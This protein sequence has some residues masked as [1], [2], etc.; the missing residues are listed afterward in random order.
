[1]CRWNIYFFVS[2]TL[3][4]KRT[5]ILTCLA[6]K[7]FLGALAGTHNYDCL[8]ASPQLATSGACY[9]ILPLPSRSQH[10]AIALRVSDWWS[11]PL[12]IVARQFWENIYISFK[13]NHCPFTPRQHN[14]FACLTLWL[15]ISRPCRLPDVRPRKIMQAASRD[16]PSYHPLQTP[17][18][19]LKVLHSAHRHSRCCSFY[20]VSPALHK[21]VYEVL[22]EEGY[23]YLWPLPPCYQSSIRR[24]HKHNSGSH[25]HLSSPLW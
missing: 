9:R 16:V 5:S 12:F 4:I 2:R 8:C 17:L 1:M 22:G 6:S 13:G 18:P 20:P 7:S 3:Q 24:S 10:A 14:F 15:R 19:P 21:D 23:V 25:L 11:V